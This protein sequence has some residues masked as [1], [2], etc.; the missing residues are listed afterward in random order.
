VLGEN[1]KKY[2]MLFLLFCF[3]ICVYSKTPSIEVQVKTDKNIPYYEW[4][5]ISAVKNNSIVIIEDG[6]ETDK[7]TTKDGDIIE[8]LSASNDTIKIRTS[9]NRAFIP[10]PSAPYWSDLIIIFSY[11]DS[12]LNEIISYPEAKGSQS[13]PNIELQKVEFEN[14]K[15]FFSYSYQQQGDS[16]Y[17]G[18]GT[19]QFEI[20]KLRDGYYY[21]TEYNCD[22][23]GYFYLVDPDDDIMV[24]GENGDYVF[25]RD[26]TMM[27]F[28]RLFPAYKNV[29]IYDTAVID[30]ICIV[31]ENLRLRENEN[32]S[33]RI[34]RTMKTGEYVKILKVGK[35]E[36]IDGIPGNW[37]YVEIVV[38]ERTWDLSD[39]INHTGV[40]GWCFS[41]YLK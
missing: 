31:Y 23:K 26:I 12:K 33:S 38:P 30:K 2:F 6:H 36:T 11:K 34:I 41:G 14:D 28:F 13:G 39:G 1:M 27:D 25:I 5:D 40:K 4:N 29:I 22:V 17:V 32:T 24:P 37:C 16:K 3:T 10:G 7:F 20:Q 9:K 18:Y 15:G 19:I 35:K 21:V 8:I